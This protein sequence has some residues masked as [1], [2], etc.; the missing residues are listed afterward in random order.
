MRLQPIIAHNINQ[1]CR[2]SKNS[3]LF[4]LLWSK[5]R[6]SKGLPR[7]PPQQTI[8]PLWR[9]IPTNQRKR[10]SLQQEVSRKS[11]NNYSSSSQASRNEINPLLPTP[12]T[13]KSSSP[14]QQQP[15]FTQTCSPLTS[16]HPVHK[17]RPCPNYPITTS[18][19]TAVA[20]TTIS[21]LSCCWKAARRRAT[22]S[23]SCRAARSQNA[24]FITIISNLRSRA[25]RRSHEGRCLLSVAGRNFS[26][27]L[28]A[29]GLISSNN[30]RWF[31][32]SRTWGSMRTIRE[33]RDKYSVWW[34][35]IDKNGFIKGKTAALMLTHPW[36]PM[37][38]KE[39]HTCQ[40][41]H[42]SS[43]SALVAERTLNRAYTCSR[44][45]ITRRSFTVW[46]KS[47][48]WLSFFLHK[49]VPFNFNFIFR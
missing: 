31:R 30:F 18:S 46:L 20:I 8:K 38:R 15:F 23:P 40:I 9:A 24:A 12:K 44:K 48:T 34:T 14:P 3:R 29:M 45:I 22:A 27:Q 33:R 10:C 39:S 47:E 17:R 21:L 28:I 1:W 11:S 16:P 43:R 36:A 6:L 7:P 49:R 4:R 32:N 26:R 25:S 19:K 41:Y 42:L 37:W 2:L 5:S 13:T 35:M